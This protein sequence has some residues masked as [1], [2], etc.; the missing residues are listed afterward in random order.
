M[1]KLHEKNVENCK[2]HSLFIKDVRKNEGKA[3]NKSR[4]KNRIREPKSQIALWKQIKIYKMNSIV[5]KLHKLLT[6]FC[7]RCG[8]KE[9]KIYEEI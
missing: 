1:S 7:L 2:K 5:K 8:E 9:G 3:R 6:Y 4:L